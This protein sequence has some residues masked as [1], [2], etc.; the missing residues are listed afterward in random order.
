MHFGG[1]KLGMLHG[2]RSSVLRQVEYAL[3]TYAYCATDDAFFFATR[4]EHPY[5]SPRRRRA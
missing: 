2:F 4:R 5:R 1:L 3:A